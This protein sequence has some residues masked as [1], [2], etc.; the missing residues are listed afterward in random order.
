MGRNNVMNKKP[1]GNHRGAE[2]RKMMEREAQTQHRR[3]EQRKSQYGMPFKFFM[4]PGESKRIFILDDEPDFFR[5]EHLMKDPQTGKYGLCTGCVKEDDNCPAC[6]ADEKDS[7]YVMYLTILDLTPFTSKQ[8]EVKFSRKL[9]PVKLSQQKKFIRRWE[10]EGT[11]RGAEFTMTRDGDKDARIGNDI[12][13]EGMVSEK[14]LS[15]YVR[16]YE[17]REGKKHTEDCSAVFDYGNLFPQPTAKSLREL[18]GGEP[19]PGSDEANSKA[20]D[21]DADD[22]PWKKEGKDSKK[23]GKKNKAEKEPKKKPKTRKRNRG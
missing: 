20:F 19:S 23:K 10:K 11:L 22:V 5:Y 17:D 9:L 2:G 8:G 16:K 13:F 14:K 3:A 4:K 21:D 7:Y 6:E 18:V 1:G 15:K 12:E